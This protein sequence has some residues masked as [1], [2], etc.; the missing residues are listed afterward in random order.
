MCFCFRCV[1][2][3]KADSWNCRLPHCALGLIIRDPML[4]N[5][6]LN[7]NQSWS[8][9]CFCVHYLWS[10]LDSI[11]MLQQACSSTADRSVICSYVCLIDDDCSAVGVLGKIPCLFCTFSRAGPDPQAEWFILG[12]N[13]L[14]TSALQLGMRAGLLHSASRALRWSFKA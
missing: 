10:S 9:C 3:Y 1:W 14:Y 8:R 2:D 5:N 11:N 7:S 12:S 4:W 13:M 6:E